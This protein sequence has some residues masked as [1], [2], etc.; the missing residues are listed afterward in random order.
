MIAVLAAACDGGTFDVDSATP[1]TREP[2]LLGA[3]F[4][5]PVVDAGAISSTFGPRWKQSAGR[6]DFHLGIDYFGAR[7]TPVLAIGDGVVEAVH[8][9]GS[10]TFPLGGNVVVVRHA[11]AQQ[12]F[13]GAMIDRVFAVYLHLDSI[14]VVAGESVAA[15]QQLGAMGDTGDTDFVHLHF[16]TRVQTMCSLPYQVAH[17]QSACVTGFD[18]HVHPFLFVPA[19]DADAIVLA[20]IDETTVRYVASRADL[21]LDVIATD[22][23][24]LGFSGRD[25]FDATSLAKLDSFDLGWVRIVPQPFTSKSGELVYDLQFA[26]T[27]RFLEVRDVRGKGLRAD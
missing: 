9:D 8:A 23:G 15:G 19:D 1:I 25:G 11:I 24:T 3:T 14:A 10:A 12:R 13:H 5:A 21:D 27:P 26:E 16:E 20:R 22:L 17:P 18:P 2:A 7:G 6:D 4:G